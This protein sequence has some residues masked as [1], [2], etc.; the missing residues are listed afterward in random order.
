MSPHLKKKS[1]VDI[2]GYQ[3]TMVLTHINE[4]VL[5]L[6]KNYQGHINHVRRA[7][8]QITAMSHQNMLLETFP[9]AR[10]Q[11]CTDML[12]YKD[13]PVGSKFLINNSL[14]LVINDRSSDS[15]EISI[16]N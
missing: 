12:K 5:D 2:K 8:I 7:Y 4:T 3:S 13:F 6:V 14:V 10:F 1:G 11:H 16:R 9:G 15:Q